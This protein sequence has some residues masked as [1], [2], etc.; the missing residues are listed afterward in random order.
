MENDTFALQRDYK[1]ALDTLSKAKSETADVIA[2]KEKVERQIEEKQGELTQV[3]NDI[4]KEKNDWAQFRHAELKDIEDKKSE[5]QSVLNWKSDLN[6]RE[7]ELRKSVAKETEIRDEARQ[8]EFKNGQD[9]TALEVKEREIEGK[10]V[11]IGIR[12]EK[13]IR[14]IGN[15]KNKVADVLD[16]VQEIQ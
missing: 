1:R 4:A 3:I 11:E 8:L 10:R 12:E 2:A 9:K 13:V 16:K 7:E 6:K 15:F 14:D 5:V